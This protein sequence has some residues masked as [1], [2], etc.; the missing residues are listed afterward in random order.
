M[1]I[2]FYLISETDTD[3][4][5]ETP[6]TAMYGMA[7]NPFKIGDEILLE[8]QGLIPKDYCNF[9]AEAKL[10]IKND[11]DRLRLLFHFE[12]VKIIRERKSIN[13]K[14][15]GH[16]ILSI[17]Y[18]CRFV[19]ATPSH[20]ERTADFSNLGEKKTRFTAAD[21]AQSEARMDRT[22]SVSEPVPTQEADV[23]NIPMKPLKFNQAL[24][25]LH[26][27][28][29]I[30]SINMFAVLLAGDYDNF[31][32]PFVGLT[33]PSDPSDF[34]RCSK[35]L[36]TVPEWKTELHK[37][38]PISETWANLVDNWDKLEAM[39]IAVEAKPKEMYFFM[40]NLGC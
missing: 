31:P 4:S 33:A 13:F 30:S 22:K 35:L 34:D 25:L 24:W 40:K 16:P 32:M 26:G 6:I 28:K 10:K 21:L 37:L 12:K 17:E 2:N 23:S 38:K 27:D 11:N 8:V 1:T 3:N 5:S 39:L 36:K 20:A 18:H 15:T 7:S 29:G 9:N 19:N 14:N